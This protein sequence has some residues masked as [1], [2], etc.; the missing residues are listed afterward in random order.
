MLL[1][2]LLGIQQLRSSPLTAA[3]EAQFI[4]IHLGMENCQLD[5]ELLDIEDECQYSTRASSTTSI[6]L[7]Q[8]SS[9]LTLLAA[10]LPSM[11]SSQWD[12]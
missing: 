11:M 8:S 10:T 9:T 5:L 1:I 12:N 4:G 3:T 6:T 2:H 7:T